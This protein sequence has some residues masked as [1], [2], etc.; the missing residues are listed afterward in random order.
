MEE[1]RTEQVTVATMYIA[2][3]AP[4]WPGASE[5]RGVIIG[6]QGGLG[7]REVEAE[8]VPAS[9]WEMIQGDRPATATVGEWEWE[10]GEA[11]GPEMP[12]SRNRSTSCSVASSASVKRA[13]SAFVASTSILPARSSVSSFAAATCRSSSL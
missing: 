12:L 5:G 3:S 2:S 11:H 9:T 8:C 4:N 10:W 1:F 6:Y 7:G 13:T